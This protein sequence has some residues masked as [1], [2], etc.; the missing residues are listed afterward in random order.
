[1]SS[2][3]KL[4]SRTAI[5]KHGNLRGKLGKSHYFLVEWFSVVSSISSVGYDTSP[6]D[7]QK[8]CSFLPLYLYVMEYREIHGN[9]EL[10]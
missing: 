10:D 3:A 9:G 5:T 8:H 6:S 7:R 1:M 2:N 4:L